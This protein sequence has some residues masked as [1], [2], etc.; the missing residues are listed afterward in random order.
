MSATKRVLL[1]ANMHDNEEL[2]PHYVAQ[3][4]HVLALLPPGSA[5][6]SIYESGST[7]AT[8]QPAAVRSGPAL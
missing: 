8:G 3:L 5:F 2:L 6:L 7:D 4:I 1:A